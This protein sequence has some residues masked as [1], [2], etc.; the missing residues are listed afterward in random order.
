V[1]DQIIILSSRDAETTKVYEEISL[2]N[3][4]EVVEMAGFPAGKG[5]EN[6]G[7][8]V[9][10]LCFKLNQTHPIT[11]TLIIC[12]P[13]M[14]TKG[15]FMGYIK[16]MKVQIQ[17][18]QGI[19][20]L[21]TIPKGPVNIS[22]MLNPKVAK[23]RANKPGALADGYWIVLQEWS[24][25]T[26]KCGGGK[27]YLQRMCVPPKSGGKPCVG[28]AVLNKDCNK[29]PCPGAIDATGKAANTVVQ[30]VNKPIV[31]IMPFSSKP[32]RYTKCVIK[33]SDM[34]YTKQMGKADS[35]NVQ[36]PKNKDS[37]D[38]IQVPVRVIMNN[39]TVTI[40]AGEDF[41]THLDSFNILT[42]NLISPLATAKGNDLACFWLNSEDGR[43][44]HLCPFGCASNTKVV[45]EWRYDFN[46]FKYQC[47]YGHKEQELNFN[48]QKKLEGKIASAKQGLMDEAQDDVKKRA[49][50]SEEKKLATHVTK[51]NAVAL[52]AIQKEINIEEMIKNEEV[53]RE[54]KEEQLMNQRIEG[55][56]DKQKCLVKAIKEKQLENQYNIRQK[57]T[58]KAVSNI[59]KAAA[60]AV[61]KRRADLKKL[62]AN[63]KKKQ[64]RKTNS[65]A[66]KLQTVRN[67]MASDMGKA[68]KK[69]SALVCKEIGNG[70]ED[71][72][73]GSLEKV[74]KR[75][76]YC[77]ASFSENYAMYQ[78]CLDSDDFCHVCCDN[79]F[80]EFFMNDRES[81]YTASC[82]ADA[83]PKVEDA[84]DTSGRWIWQNQ[85]TN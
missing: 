11:Q 25:C 6:Y 55:E 82:D 20:L 58:E 28:D 73:G 80:G 77:I 29:Q 40:Y 65:L 50:K 36:V 14:K 39:R 30:K 62:I 33:E 19:V 66:V 69:G 1:K 24:Q 51:T 45:D 85:V 22:G 16:K 49:Q 27:S 63:M 12:S 7:N 70:T 76:H 64:L 47:N 74:E 81:C 44:A 41:D 46:L 2:K 71:G 23:E 68:Y 26:L 43:T 32:Q 57:D 78:T 9:G 17:R 15:S 37:T 38:T 59:K 56:K 13:D 54:R 42:S 18:D 83:P 4:G 31:K 48:L 34:M 35:T 79:E 21:P 84:K 61:V 10:G 53:E 75:K 67:S 60:Q 8:F 72:N 3:L 52:Q 5:I